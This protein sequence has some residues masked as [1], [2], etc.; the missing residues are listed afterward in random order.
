M[1][2]DLG[3][4]NCTCIIHPSSVH[5]SDC[6]FLPGDAAAQDGP[7]ILSP[8]MSAPQVECRWSSLELVEFV[9]SLI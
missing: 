1:S 4:H 5:Y 3:V 7:S 9:N 8:Q 2:Y 6:L